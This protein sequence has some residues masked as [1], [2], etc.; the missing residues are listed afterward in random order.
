MTYVRTF[1][2]TLLAFAAFTASAAFAQTATSTSDATV[3]T[4]NDLSITG[5]GIVTLAPTLATPATGDPTD[6]AYETN[7]GATYKIVLSVDVDGWTFTPA[8]GTPAANTFPQLTVETVTAPEGS[9]TATGTLIS[10]TNVLTSVDVVSDLVNVKD[11][12]SVTLGASITETV[13]SGTYEAGLTYT[14]T[15][16]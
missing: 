4:V 6:L 16:Q 14:W 12:A 11:T 13:V 8:S 9:T 10:A 2:T 1:A 3:A 7:D 15:A 5:G